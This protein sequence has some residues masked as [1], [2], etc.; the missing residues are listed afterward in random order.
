M[1]NHST[2]TQNVLEVAHNA[3]SGLPLRAAL[4]Q[5]SVSSTE[6]Y[7]VHSAQKS[8][9]MRVVDMGVITQGCNFP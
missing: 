1:R 5:E 6:H 4:L 3:Y 8:P 9:A 2:T 7:M